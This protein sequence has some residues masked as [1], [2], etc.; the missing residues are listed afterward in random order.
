MQDGDVHFLSDAPSS[1]R[2]PTRAMNMTT[3]LEGAIRGN[4]LQNWVGRVCPSGG[5]TE[6]RCAKDQVLH[7]DGPHGCLYTKCHCAP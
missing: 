4:G 6:A 3:V 2:V 1:E 5:A 7:E